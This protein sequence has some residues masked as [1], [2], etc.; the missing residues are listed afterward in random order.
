MS[1]MLSFAH[2]GRTRVVLYASKLA[3]CAGM[4]PYCSQ[5]ELADEFRAKVIGRPPDGWATAEAKAA[6]AIEALPEH[7]RTIAGDAIAGAA[8]FAD[9]S[10]AGS[11]LAT[12]A[13]AEGMTAEALE[14]VRE[15]I[16]TAQ[17]SRQEPEV[18]DRH[19]LSRGSRLM[20]CA[21]FRTSQEPLLEIRGLRVHIGG[22]HD[23][24]DRANQ[25]VVEIKTRQRRFLGVPRYELVQLHAYMAIFGM[26]RALLV[27][28]FMGEEREHE[29][30]FDD[31]LWER[32]RVSVDEFVGRCL[33]EWLGPRV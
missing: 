22:K 12:A 28:S 8:S 5:E 16:F 3:A 11:A 10:V 33:D 18:R 2:V 31:D 13:A 14:V 30:Q 21:R 1:V 29:V 15:R 27:E 4:N 23:G 19:E 7:A 24:L 9:A 6:A 26:R 17:G 25:M 20:Q 32:V